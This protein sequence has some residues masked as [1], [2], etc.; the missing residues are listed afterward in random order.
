M[1]NSFNNNN[2][3]IENYEDGK[4]YNILNFFLSLVFSKNKNSSQ[5]FFYFENSNK[6]FY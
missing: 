5:I 2:N 1:F 4:N 3:F 6:N